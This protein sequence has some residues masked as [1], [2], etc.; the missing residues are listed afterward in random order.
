MRKWGRWSLV[1]AALLMAS[2]AH[3]PISLEPTTHAYTGE[4]YERIYRAWSRDADDFSWGDLRDVLL[5][6]ATFEAPEFRW[7]YIARYA[8]DHGIG[9]AERTDLLRASLADAE[10]KH[11]F[12]V[13]L[14]GEVYREANLTRRDSAWRVLLVDE[15]GR[16][17]APVE[18]EHVRRP[19]AAERV[20]FPSI[21][22]YRHAFR[23]V[24]PAHHPDGS[25]VLAPD[26]TRAML[27]FTGARGTVDLLWEFEA[28]APLSSGG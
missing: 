18:I 8:E 15:E 16:T 10:E 2:C 27:R 4:D 19:S 9:P 20:Y 13:T 28:D 3:H 1:L 14:A 23:V 22:P 21:N 24:F 26:A 7:A 25:P 12:F 5:V 11:R 17:M 6:T